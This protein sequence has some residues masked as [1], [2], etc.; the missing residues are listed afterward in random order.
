MY[1]SPKDLK[2]SFD[3]KVRAAI[4]P[5]VASGWNVRPFFSGWLGANVAIERYLVGGGDGLCEPQA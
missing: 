2:P 1:E 4:A 5:I 3:A